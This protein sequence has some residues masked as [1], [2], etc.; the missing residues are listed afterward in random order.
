MAANVGIKNYELRIKDQVNWNLN[1]YNLKAVMDG[2]WRK[3]GECDEYIQKTEP[4]KKVK[5][6][7]AGAKNDIEHLLSELH[8]IALSLQPFLP[9]SADNILNSLNNL[10]T[11]NIPRLFPRIS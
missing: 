9:F 1:G 8:Q 2:I 10:S 7:E 5:T 4:F 11:E 6:D 3:V